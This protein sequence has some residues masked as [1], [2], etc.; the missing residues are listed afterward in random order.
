MQWGE[1]R[2][3]VDRLGNQTSGGELHCEIMPRS[4]HSN[5]NTFLMSEHQNEIW[6]VRAASASLCRGAMQ[7]IPEAGSFL[8]YN[9]LPN[10]AR[11]K[12]REGELLRM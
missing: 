8:S 2:I 6:C 4:R 11:L 7:E 3:I 5:S 12:M 1:R 10:N 9:K